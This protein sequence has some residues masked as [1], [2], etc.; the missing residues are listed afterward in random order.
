MSV[1]K[2]YWVFIFTY[3]SMF[4]LGMGD[5]VRGPL[6]S[7]LLSNFHLSNWQGSFSFAIASTAALCGNIAS[8]YLFKKFTLKDVLTAALII[9]F[10]GL[11]SMG[12]ANQF[13]IY[14]LGSVLFGVSMG[15]LGVTQT[16]LISETVQPEQQSKAMSGMHGI[17]GL[18]SLLAP[19]VAAQSAHIFNFWQAGF[20]VVA[21]TTL[22]FALGSIFLKSNPN[23]VVYQKPENPNQVSDEKNSLLSLLSIGGIFAFYV[24]AEIMVSSRLALYMR[25]YFQMD[26]DGSSEYVTY[27]FIFLLAGRM[28]FAI[29]AF[30]VSLKRQLNISLCG[31]LLFLVLGL[32]VHPFFLVLLGFSMAPY[33]PLSIT[34][35]SEQT[36]IYKKRQFLTFALSFQSLCVIT[37]HM[38]VGYLTDHF[39]LFYAFGVGIISLV[40]A[41]VCVNVHPKV[42]SS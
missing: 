30:P 22:I 28:L 29:K 38:G 11:L 18:S 40:L 20:F 16:L 32:K 41:L 17:Y 25:T 1:A 10:A 35:I 37:M 7:D 42:Y 21:A 36:G 3:L 34:Y 39:G 13:S 12:L 8:A 14:V 31:S 27:F 2:K 19:I 23:F 33:Y 24:V 4:V 9:M 6:F 5:N 15:L 26:L